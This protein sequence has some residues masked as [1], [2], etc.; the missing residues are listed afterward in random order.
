MAGIDYEPVNT[1]ITFEKEVLEA[2]IHIRLIDNQI[3]QDMRTFSAVIEVTQGLI[4]PAQV[5]N[6]TATIEIED[7]DSESHIIQC[8]VHVHVLHVLI[9]CFMGMYKCFE[10]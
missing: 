2:T 6:N 10:M 8:H 9:N 4:Y 5:E 1:M 7:D 3:L